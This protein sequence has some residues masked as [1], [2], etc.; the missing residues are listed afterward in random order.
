MSIPVYTV[1]T[2]DGRRLRGTIYGNG[3]MI[4][5]EQRLVSAL[6]SM[7]KW[8]GT[9]VIETRPDDPDPQRRYDRVPIAD[10]VSIDDAPG[11]WVQGALL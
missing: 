4:A 7:R 9:L 6:R 11:D 2:S 10:V 5:S 8:G 3:G 1:T